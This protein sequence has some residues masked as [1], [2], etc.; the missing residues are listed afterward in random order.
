[1]VN[2]TLREPPLFACIVRRTHCETCLLEV[3]C[4]EP[5]M[6]RWSHRNR[7]SRYLPDIP[8]RNVC[9]DDDSNGLKTFI[10][11]VDLISAEGIR[12]SLSPIQSILQIAEPRDKRAAKKMLG[13][14]NYFGKLIRTLAERTKLLCRIIKKDEVFEWTQT[15]QNKGVEYPT[16]R[17]A[18]RSCGC[19]IQQEKQRSRVTRHAVA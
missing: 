12:P 18:N 16:V 3:L 19:S 11:H 13:V 10:T 8:R 15:P 6:R 14:V 17:V 1:M 5:Q 4:A 2:G 9:Y 7:F